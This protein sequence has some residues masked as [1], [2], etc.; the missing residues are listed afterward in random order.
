LEQI[1]EVKKYAEMLAQKG[2]RKPPSMGQL[3][4][5]TSNILLECNRLDDALYY[6]R[7]A[8]KICQQWGEMENLFSALIVL[9]RVHFFRGEYDEFER[10]FDR[11]LQVAAKVSKYAYEYVRVFKIQF[12]ALQGKT[13]EIEEWW[14]DHELPKNGGFSHSKRLAYQNFTY[15]LCSKGLYEEALEILDKLIEMVDRVD[16]QLFSMRYK[17]LQAKFLYTVNQ[18]AAA[19][20]SLEDALQIASPQGY[21]RAF[22]D[23]GE[24]VAHLLYQAAQMGIYPDYCQM[25]L[26]E[27]SKEIPVQ[28]VP[29]KGA[30]DL[31][32]PL[33]PREMEVLEHIALGKTNQEISQA[34]YISL[35]TVKSH[36][37]NIFGKLGVKNRTEAVAKARLIGLLTKE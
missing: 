36:A 27:F 2:G 6:A 22:L 26:D 1:T 21:V 11:S 4:R 28:Q 5:Q 18:P 24:I 19:I 29:S 20:E 15:L 14:P 25:L 7:E 34:L 12:L 8:H 3:Y 9:A 35:Y 33:S 31:I 17:V 32:E 37:R 10:F 13:G 30:G 23:G 16:L